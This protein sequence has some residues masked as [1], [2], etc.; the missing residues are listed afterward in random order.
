MFGGILAIVP[1]TDFHA[2]PGI[3]KM[4]TVYPGL[5]AFLIILV[6][7]LIIHQDSDKIIHSTIIFPAVWIPIIH[8]AYLKRCVWRKLWLLVESSELCFERAFNVKICFERQILLIAGSYSVL[9]LF[10][11]TVKLAGLDNG[12][13]SVVTFYVTYG[14]VVQI[15]LFSILKL[16]LRLFNKQLKMRM[17]LRMLYHSVKDRF[18]QKIYK[19]LYGI[20]V[21]LNEVYGFP[22]VVHMILMMIRICFYMQ[23]TLELAMKSEDISLVLLNRNL[24]LIFTSVRLF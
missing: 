18:Y 2:K 21:C 8:A 11:E 15:L 20:A 23:E 12:L 24:R 1:W 6:Y 3:R 4:S 10:V 5:M 13:N 17:E 19:Q 7:F 22:L 16:G 14:L 9:F